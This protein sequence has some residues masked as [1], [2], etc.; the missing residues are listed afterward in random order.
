MLYC[1]IVN[2]KTKKYIITIMETKEM[3]S[4]IGAL[5]L[6]ELEKLVGESAIYLFIASGFI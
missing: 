1:D 3:K 6:I 2:F 4:L 5:I